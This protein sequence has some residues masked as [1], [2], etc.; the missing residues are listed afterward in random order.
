MVQAKMGD[1]VKV[2]YTGTVGQGTVF[3]TTDGKEAFE[4]T[5]GGR[6]VIAGFEQAVIG[7]EPGESTTVR[8]PAK[9]AYGPHRKERVTAVRRDQ[10][11]GNVE[12]AVGQRLV[13]TQEDGRPMWVTVVAVSGDS[14]TLDANHPL[15]GQDLVFAIELV[16]IV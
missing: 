4:F 9:D 14:V 13:M 2:H 15:A 10:L 3:D 8:V 11:P 16:E 6:E 5:I 1:T 12:P 7:L